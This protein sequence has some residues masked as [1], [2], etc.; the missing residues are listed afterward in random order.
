MFVT[1]ITHDH[2]TTQPKVYVSQGG[3]GMLPSCQTAERLWLIQFAFRIQA[4]ELKGLLEEF[5]ELFQE[6][7]KRDSNT[8][9]H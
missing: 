7:P 2:I 3:V 4:M 1:D 5:K 6:M 8:T 9:A